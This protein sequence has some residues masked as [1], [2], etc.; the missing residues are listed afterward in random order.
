MKQ[1][2]I[3]QLD[4]MGRGAHPPVDASVLVAAIEI[5]EEV[6]NNGEA[7]L[8]AYNHRFGDESPDGKLIYSGDDLEEA[9]ANLEESTAALL[10][11]ISTRIETFATAQRRSLKDVEVDVPGGRAGHRWIPVENVGAYAPGGR[12]PLPSTVLMTVVPARVAGVGQTWVASPRPSEIM[13]ASAHVAGAEGV[14]GVGGAQAIAALAFGTISPPCSLIVGPGNKW[15]TAAKKYLYGEVGIDGLAGPSEI[16]VIADARSDPEL[17]A[18][19][20]LAQAEHDPEARPLLVSLDN[21]LIRIVEERLK[22]LLSDLPTAGVARLA[23]DNGIAVAVE[24]LVEAA[25]VS[26]AIAPEHLAIHIEAPDQIMGLLTNYGSVFVGNMAS[27]AVADYGIG[28]NHVLPTGG[29]ARFQSGLSVSTFLKSPTW[30]EL[31]DPDLVSADTA[32]L[33][34]LEG[35]EGHARSALARRR[36]FD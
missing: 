30:L 17:V 36:N 16:L 19:D 28:P 27:E 26:N 14:I 15:V 32:A 3:A 13:L 1:L 20:L 5:V 24:N 10:G 25:A 29:T 22:H 18:H 31:N 21:E 4:D 35:L 6:R 2:M 11:R 7:A 34:R 12:Y 9:Y 33:A 23:L 8:H